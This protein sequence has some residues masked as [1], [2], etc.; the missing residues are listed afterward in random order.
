[1]K[2][3]ENSRILASIT[4]YLR[5]Y[6]YILVPKILYSKNMTEDSR[7]FS[8]RYMILNTK[9]NSR[10]KKSGMNIDS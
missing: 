7:I 1:M 9:K 5:Y 2:V 10:K 8:K 6:H 4:H 3:S